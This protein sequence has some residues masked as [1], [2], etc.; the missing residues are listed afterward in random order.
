M[1]RSVLL[2]SGYTARPFAS[3]Y[4]MIASMYAGRSRVMLPLKVFDCSSSAIS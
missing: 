4:A 1:T 3:L 2:A